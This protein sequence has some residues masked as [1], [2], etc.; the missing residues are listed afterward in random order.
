M[1]AVVQRVTSASVEVDGD[2]VAAI[3]R[4]F[5]ALVGVARDDSHDD[6]QAIASKIAGLRIFNDESG[7]MDLG[8][9]DVGGSVLAVSQFTLYGDA[10]RGRRPSFV[11]AAG[12]D[13]A[14]PLFNL[15]VERLRREGV[16]V[17][18]GVFGARMHVQLVN[19][20]PVTILLDS[21]KL[22]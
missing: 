8:L 21:R 2:V 22:F 14:L 4:G 19:E 7:S 3:E 11:E 12:S 15:T 13:V 9:S 17:Q 6:A 20:G 1:R 10:R 18:T 5:L 16:T